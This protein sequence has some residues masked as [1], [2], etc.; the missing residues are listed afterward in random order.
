MGG[1]SGSA[2][3]GAAGGDPGLRRSYAAQLRQ[4]VA[5]HQHYPRVARARRIEGDGAVRFRIDRSGRLLYAV[6]ARSTGHAV[7]D[8]ELL[9]ML[10]RASPLPPMPPDLPGDSH[11]VILPAGFA[12]R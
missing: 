11:E 2:A 3:E 7:L 6:V 5:R 4:W 1:A 12:L 10:R 8:E 9:A